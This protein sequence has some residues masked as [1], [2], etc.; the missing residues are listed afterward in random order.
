MLEDQIIDIE[1][2]YAINITNKGRLLLFPLKQLPVLSKGKGNKMINIPNNFLLNNEEFLLF[3]DIISTS[4][5]LIIFSGKRKLTLSNQDLQTFISD[6]GRRGT[7]L[8]RGFQ[9][10]NKIS[11]VKN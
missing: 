10:V 9:K 5:S 8:P 7:L 2:E 11:I 4:S 3:A 1:N 6:R